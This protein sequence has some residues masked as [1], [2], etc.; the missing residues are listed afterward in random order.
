MGTINLNGYFEEKKRDILNL[1]KTEINAKEHHIDIL[2]NSGV[3]TD[4]H[5]MKLIQLKELHRKIG[6]IQEDI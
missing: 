6:N 5:E 1:L 2:S 4:N 3:N